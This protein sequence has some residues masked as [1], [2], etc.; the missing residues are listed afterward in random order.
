MFVILSVSYLQ[1]GRLAC[2]LLELPYT[3]VYITN[4]KSRILCFQ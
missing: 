4:S 1:I 3:S 2:N